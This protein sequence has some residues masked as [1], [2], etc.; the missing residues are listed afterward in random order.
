MHLQ[1]HRLAAALNALAAQ[2]LDPGRA[3]VFVTG[4]REAHHVSD[5][6]GHLG[7]PETGAI[8][9]RLALGRLASTASQ[10]A[11]WQVFSVHPGR[12][13][14]LRG[15][16]EVT[17]LAV[18]RGAIVIPSTGGPTWVPL[19]LGTQEQVRAVQWLLVHANRPTPP[20]LPSEAQDRLRQAMSESEEGLRDM[21]PRAPQPMPWRPLELPPGYSASSQQ[22]L[23]TAQR[24]AA[25]AAGARDQA[26]GSSSFEFTRSEHLLNELYYAAVETLDSVVSWPQRA[27][28]EIELG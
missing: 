23:A 26:V 17:R 1:A 25:A 8:P 16:T 5:P 20:A 19:V 28:G 21:A 9:L 12:L 27:L 18:D 24:V 11:L 15:P 3:E 10:H 4:G 7:L 22:L 14:G 2:D 13:G 6:D